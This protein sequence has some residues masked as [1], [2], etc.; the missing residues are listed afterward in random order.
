MI[1]TNDA[2]EAAKVAQTAT[3][4]IDKYGDG[5]L[6]RAVRLEQDSASPQFA[7]AVRA[8]VERRIGG[9]AART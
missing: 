3:A 9:G 1:A 5:A 6:V 8:E 4:L 7:A 2:V